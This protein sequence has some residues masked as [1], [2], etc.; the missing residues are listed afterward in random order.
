MF[1]LRRLSRKMSLF[2]DRLKS[3]DPEMQGLLEQETRRQAST[4]NL[5]ASENYTSKAVLDV[6]GTPLQNKYS[7]GFPGQRYYGGNEVIDK[8]ENLGIARAKQL[9]GLGDEWGVCMQALSGAPANFCVYMGLIEPGARAM[10]LLLS[11]GG[12]LTHG[13]S[14]PTKKVHFTSKVWDWEHFAHSPDLEFDYPAILEQAKRF[15][16]KLLMAGYSAYPRHFDYAKLREICDAVGAYLVADVAHI[17]GLIAAKVAP[18]PF[19]H[20][21]VVVTTTHKTLRG[22]RGALIFAR[23]AGDKASP[24]SRIK[25]ALFP[26]FQGGPHN[27]TI[28]GIAVALKEAQRPEFAEYQRNVLKNAQTLAKELMQNGVDV[29]SGGTENHLLLV[30]L[31]GRG[32][33]GSRAE[34]MLNSM[35]IIVN[36]NTLL[37]D[38]S[39]QKP[40]GIRLGSAPM[41]TR[42]CAQKDFA[43]IASL[44]ARVLQ[45]ADS[46]HNPKE[47]LAQY[48]ALCDDLIRNN[49][50]AK[51]LKAEIEGFSL[52]FPFYEMKF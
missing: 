10:G 31:R 16:P 9:F 47:K 4:V 32:I 49:E 12:H 34:H 3:S 39:A 28:A 15:Q 52:Q 18:D 19:P 44:I 25:E 46:I 38:L 41:T 8:I 20:C 2:T 7:E 29:V 6:L 26:G 45:W 36:K 27:H 48:K 37:G 22:P 13:F 50:K 17:A 35:G 24:F 5:I 43:Q 42:G 51:S 30:D 23:T 14:L 11:S 21:D 1:A 40:S 33:D